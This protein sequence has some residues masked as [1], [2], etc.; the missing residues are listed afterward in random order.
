M[1]VLPM[2]IVTHC[3]QGL[4]LQSLVATGSSST[5]LRKLS[6]ENIHSLSWS[7]YDTIPFNDPR[8]LLPNTKETMNWFI[9]NLPHLSRLESITYEVYAGKPHFFHLFLKYLYQQSLSTP[10]SPFL[11]SFPLT[12]LNL[13]YSGDNK[14]L[15]LVLEYHH[16]TLQNFRFSTHSIDTLHRLCPSSSITFPRL[17]KLSINILGIHLV[18]T[19]DVE[20]EIFSIALEPLFTSFA[21]SGSLRQLV[22]GCP[23]QMNVVEV[24]KILHHHH[25]NLSSLHLRGVEEDESKIVVIH[26]KP[27]LPFPMLE[28]FSLEED[29]EEGYRPNVLTQ[30]V[31]FFPFFMPPSLKKLVLGNI[32]SPIFQHLTTT[33]PRLRHLEIGGYGC[34][35]L[36]NFQH[37]ATDFY[38]FLTQTNIPF[39]DTLHVPFSLFC[40]SNISENNSFKN[41]KKVKHINV[42]GFCHLPHDIPFLQQLGRLFTE[43]NVEKLFWDVHYQI[44]MEENSSDIEKD[45]QKQM[46]MIKGMS[47][48]PMIPTMHLQDALSLSQWTWLTSKFRPRFHNYVHHNDHNPNDDNKITDEIREWEMWIR[49]PQVWVLVSFLEEW[50]HSIEHF[51]VYYM[52]SY[53]YRH[54]EE[55]N[56]QQEFEEYLSRLCHFLDVF[57]S[58]SVTFPRLRTLR[59]VMNACN[60]N[61]HDALA[62][63]HGFEDWEKRVRQK[64]PVL[65]HLEIGWMNHKI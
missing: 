35:N 55:P 18:E 13:E 54:G 10:P 22:L 36:Q 48:F 3:L 63:I 27:S 50:Q 33:C 2:E 21:R 37:H 40:F 38:S 41:L 30:S 56:Y 6:L 8:R 34:M 4:D 64:C 44:D 24:V 26:Q 42:Y 49:F 57:M 47:T 14:G 11:P 58:L 31:D 25:V 17:K 29:D 7:P 23:Y 43:W 51:T 16:Q 9:Q 65:R 15:P 59:I 1:D 32:S 12:T 52:Y 53:T 20:A 61:T 28:S 19:I 60:S 5:L 62:S 46:G 39:L 45:E